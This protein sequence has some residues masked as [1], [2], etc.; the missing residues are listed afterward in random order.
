MI[1]FGFVVF[2]VLNK[3]KV[4]RLELFPPTK[5]HVIDF[6]DGMGYDTSG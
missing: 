6:G 3:I 1:F 5:N 2:L 4:A